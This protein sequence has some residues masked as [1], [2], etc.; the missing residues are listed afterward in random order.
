MTS[1]QNQVAEAERRMAGGGPRVIRWA[2]VAFPYILAAAWL[3]LLIYTAPRGEPFAI[4][5]EDGY[6]EWA[7]VYIMLAG[8]LL[9]AMAVVIHRRALTR[10]QRI[11]LWLFA[12]VLVVA[13]G[14]ELSWGQRFFGVAAHDVVPL[15][16][17]TT[18]QIGHGDLAVHNLT[19]KTRWFKFSIGGALFGVVLLAGLVGHGIWLPWSHARGG[20]LAKGIVVKT[21]TFLPPID[22][23]ILVS[24]LTLLVL[25]RRWYENIEANEYKEF[26]VPAIYACVLVRL[27]FAG[28]TRREAVVAAGFMFCTLAY[29]AGSVLFYI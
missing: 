13:A 17:D 8:A 3:A 5:T 2:V 6:I 25:R 7:T 29:L 19:I 21:G 24:V 10:R 16:K 28:G 20:A 15:S 18:L 26:I 12:V 9:S 23:G 4:S 11:F 22:L 14:E 27:F 1:S